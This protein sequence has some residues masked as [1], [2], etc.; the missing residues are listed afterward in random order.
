M[1]IESQQKCGT[2]QVEVRTIPEERKT[3]PGRI[4]SL[5]WDGH[6]FVACLLGSD[7]NVLEVYN[8]LELR[9]YSARL[10]CQVGDSKGAG[11]SLTVKVRTDRLVAANNMPS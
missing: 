10:G 11:Q 7:S 8:H 3:K 5:F 6:I 4:R 9:G 2:H 1:S